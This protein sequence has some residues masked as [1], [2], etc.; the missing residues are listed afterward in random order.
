MDWIEI[1]GDS[2]ED[3]ETRAK[4]ALGV[5]DLEM[6][7]VE[8]LK[9]MRKFMGMGGTKYKIRARLKDEP[10][11]A[12]EPVLVAEEKEPEAEEAPVVEEE[13]FVRADDSPLEED[14]VTMDSNYRPW[15]SE[16]PSGVVIPKKGRG[17]GRKLYSSEPAVAV[18]AVA[19]AKPAQ[20]KA[21]EEVVYEE[22]A[23]EPLEP[24]TYEDVE[25]SSITEEARDQTVDFI[26]R[27]LSD[28]GFEE[29]A[30]KGYRLEDR[31]MVQISSESSG[32]L[33]GRK[34]ETLESLQY[35]A[36]IVVN[37]SREQR[38]R[39]ILD[40][41]D[42]REKRKRKVFQLAKSA[43]NDAIKSR[44]PVSLSPMNPSERRY[45]HM[46]LASNVK[47]ETRSEGEGSRRRVV[48]HPKGGNKG[49]GGGGNKGKGKGPRRRR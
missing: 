3:V 11:V 39:L 40:A 49:F 46:C 48:V 1:E 6:L 13:E 22:V 25:N 45:A 27:T 33:I 9:V 32:L 41:D 34:G 10:E 26:L 35:L 21:R 42:Y 28:M 20:P 4:E 38:I 24:V 19:E 16:G 5:S 14:V 44:R 37:R 12:E 17:F 47:V 31:L 7:E 29:P 36:E 18:V 15:V 2:K 8:E 23:E 43:A 30:V